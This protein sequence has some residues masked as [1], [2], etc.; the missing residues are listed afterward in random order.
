MEAYTIWELKKEGL[1]VADNRELPAEVPPKVAEHELSHDAFMTG[2]KEAER[3]LARLRALHSE[4]S[5]QRRE[6]SEEQR[7]RE[8]A[9][10][11]PP[12]PPEET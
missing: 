4:R 5:A 6:R 1:G 2:C 7:E 8:L 9:A 11:P 3:D 10:G 12:L